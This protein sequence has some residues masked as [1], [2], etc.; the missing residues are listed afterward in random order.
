MGDVKGGIVIE[1]MKRYAEKLSRCVDRSSLVKIEVWCHLYKGK[2]HF[3]VNMD[4][5][6]LTIPKFIRAQYPTNDEAH[7]L[8]ELGKVIDKFIKQKEGEKKN[9]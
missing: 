5:T 9:G 1:Q 4:C 3:D 7:D 2:R 6:A 8:R